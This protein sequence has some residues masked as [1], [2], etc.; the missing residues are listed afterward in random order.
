MTSR[1]SEDP[2]QEPSFV[3]LHASRASDGLVFRAVLSA[4]AALELQAELESDD[5]SVVIGPVDV[6][7]ED[8]QRARQGS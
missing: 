5:W 2:G 4:P 7:A 3:L 8:A 6:E 1:D